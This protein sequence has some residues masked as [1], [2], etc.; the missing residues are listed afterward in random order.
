MK[1]L[2]ITF[3]AGFFLAGIIG[4]IFYKRIG[5][6]MEYSYMDKLSLG[7]DNTSTNSS[8]ASNGEA[9][10]TERE[11]EEVQTVTDETGR[12]Q[13]LKLSS[14]NTKDQG[15]YLVESNPTACYSQVSDGHYYF[16]RSD[17]KG[18]YTIYMDKGNQVGQFS[19]DNGGYVKYFGKYKNNY[20]AV[21]T[22]EKEDEEDDV[23]LDATHKLVQVDLEKG[24]TVFLK[25]IFSE[26]EWMS[27]SRMYL[28]F[29]QDAFYHDICNKVWHTAIY[30]T[31]YIPGKLMR[32]NR[33]GEETEIDSTS[34][35]NDAKPCLTFI[36]GKI[37][38]GSQYGTRKDRKINLFSY[39]LESGR[40]KSIFS[41]ERE[42]EFSTGGQGLMA[43]GKINLSIDD[44][45]IYCQ[46]YI[47]P[48]RGGKMIR[49]FK[50]AMLYQDSTISFSYNS[51]YIYYI[52][53]K[54]RVRRVDKKTL[55]NTVISGIESMDV[56]CTEKDVYVREYKKK[57][58]PGYWDDATDAQLT[59]NPD[60]N[61]IYCMDLNGN[62][63]E[64]IVKKVNY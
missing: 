53:K 19:V 61:D 1:K 23:F 31:I 29:Y 37:Y 35:M 60:S 36:D 38:Y 43:Q 28:F 14:I 54:H 12:N 4:I 9:N 21:L 26:H 51:Q 59:D 2:F 20:Y 15:M 56:K 13:R 42:T 62:H 44:D 8:F 27:D 39:D 46:D 41:F 16:M 63:A 18:N 58:L 48:R 24:E 32:V 30:D 40:E 25:D 33:K 52:D 49:V 10:E 57:L 64:K 17:G 50:D 5:T 22:Y 6:H 3:F 47:I 45:Y 34:Y 7:S 11:K 55:K